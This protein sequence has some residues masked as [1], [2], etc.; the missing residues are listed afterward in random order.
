MF[1]ERKKGLILVE[2]NNF[3]AGTFWLV[4]KDQRWLVFSEIA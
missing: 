3:S 4:A 2:L 1:L